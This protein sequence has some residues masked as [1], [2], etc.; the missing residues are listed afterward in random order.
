MPI[1]PA[2]TD[3]SKLDNVA[4]LPTA[5]G[6][7][8]IFQPGYA[9]TLTYIATGTVTSSSSLANPTTTSIYISPTP[10]PKIQEYSSLSNASQVGIGAGVGIAGL[11]L[12]GVVAVAYVLLRRKKA[13]GPS[14]E[15]NGPE[16]AAPDSK[17][18]IDLAQYGS[19]TTTAPSELES[20]AAWPWAVRSELPDHT[21]QATA[22]EVSGESKRLSELPA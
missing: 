6:E 18:A 12:I 10:S 13:K 2:F 9:P 16:D 14:Q 7:S 11:L 15:S 20:I 1:F 21:G 8:I 5:S 4:Q 3:K 17:H 19:P 22:V